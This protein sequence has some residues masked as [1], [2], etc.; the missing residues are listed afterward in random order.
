MA[1]YFFHPEKI[2][3]A[4]YFAPPTVPTGDTT[5]PAKATYIQETFESPAGI[6]WANLANM[7]WY[8]F[9]QVWPTPLG[10]PVAQG[11][12]ETTDGVAVDVFDIAGKTSLFPGQVGTLGY[13]NTNGDPDQADLI[14]WFSPVYVR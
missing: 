7:R 5:L 13:T 11:D 8:F 1:D 9:D 4:Y 6:P 10:A 3:G 14:S 12:V 2:G